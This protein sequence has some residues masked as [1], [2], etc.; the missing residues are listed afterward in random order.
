M[1]AVFSREKTLR[2]K[3]LLNVFNIFVHSNNIGGIVLVSATIF[4]LVAA[5]LDSFYAFRDFWT[6]NAGISLGSFTIEM[7]LKNWVNDFL[8]AL[9][10]FVVGL[11]IK[12]EMI[13]GELSSLKLA[14]LPIFAAIG[15]MIVPALLFHLFNQGTPS[16][17]GWG[18]PMATDIAFSLGVISLL[19]RSVPVSLKIFLTALAIVDDIG[20]IIVLALFYPSHETEG[21]FL[22]MAFG[23]IV[24]LLILNRLKIHS[25]GFYLIPGIFLW[26]FVLNSGVH[27]TIAGVALAMCIPSSSSINEVR[28][29][30]KSKYFLD[31][32]KK[33]GN[34]EVNILANSSQLGIIGKLHSH[35]KEINPLINRLEH[36]INPWITFSIIPVFALAN[37]GVVFTDIS[38]TQGVSPL[39]AG[40]FFGLL[41]GKPIGII[42]SSF[43]ACKLKIAELPDDI[44]WSH[45]FSAGIIAGIGFT[46]SIFIDSL[47]FS[48]SA[49]INEGKAA[50]LV[51]SFIAAVTGLVALRLALGKPEKRIKY[52]KIREKDL[53]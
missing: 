9:F 38:W 51:T 22:L 15:G 27:A 44:R 41:F 10:F 45:L 3:K 20:S 28:F 39:S 23:V 5:N 31:K 33:A 47:A 1:S 18:I 17:N 21:S 30:V 24:L 4:A 2:K 14:A 37:A 42:I 48:N 19:G 12:R 7:S 8:M 34:S 49:L 29:Y 53:L 46:M 16:E 11:E 13:A 32:F 25:A 52:K 40:I 26:Y 36:T 6:I 35:I 43:I 50:I